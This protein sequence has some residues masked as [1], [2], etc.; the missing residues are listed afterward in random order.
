MNVITIVGRV[1]RDAEVK[2]FG[3]SSATNFS[4]AVNRSY[5]NREGKY[6]ADF[7]NCSVR[8]DKIAQY[9]TKGKLISV[10]GSM[11]MTKNDN[12]TYWSLDGSNCNPFLEKSENN[13]TFNQQSGGNN[14]PDT[15]EIPF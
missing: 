7:F 8:G 12:G 15:N 13:G 11:K 3:D 1:T 5:K 4:V 9:I 6:D 2:N 10:T 14:F